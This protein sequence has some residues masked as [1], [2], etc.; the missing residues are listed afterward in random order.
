MKLTGRESGGW[1]VLDKGGAIRGSDFQ[2]IPDKRS[3]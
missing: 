2:I 3:L 1:T